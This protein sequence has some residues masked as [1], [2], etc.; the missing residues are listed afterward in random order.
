MPFYLFSLARCPKGYLNYKNSGLGDSVMVDYRPKE[1]EKLLRYLGGLTETTSDNLYNHQK[2]AGLG[3]FE[4]GDKHIPQIM[5]ILE[6]IGR[7]WPRKL[8]RFT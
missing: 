5:R 6:D 2:E 4:T 1:F 7:D 3:S 8:K